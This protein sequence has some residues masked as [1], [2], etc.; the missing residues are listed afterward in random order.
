MHSPLTHHH[1]QTGVER[2]GQGRIVLGKHKRRNH[3]AVRLE[4]LE[5]ISS[6][7]NPSDEVCH[8][9]VETRTNPNSSRDDQNKSESPVK[10]IEIERGAHHGTPVSHDAHPCTLIAGNWDVPTE[11]IPGHR[12]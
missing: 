11:L 4:N 10:V 8:L 6:D 3:W 2:F 7:T 12:A 5:S 1:V 9:K